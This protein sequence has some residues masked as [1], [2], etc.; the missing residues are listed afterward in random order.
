MKAYFYLTGSEISFL[1][2][3]KAQLFESRS[4]QT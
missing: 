3:T 4:M 1:L 2:I